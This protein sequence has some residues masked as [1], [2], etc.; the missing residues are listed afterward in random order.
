MIRALILAYLFA[1]VAELLCIVAGLILEL[2]KGGG[3]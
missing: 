3:L 2:L 1:P